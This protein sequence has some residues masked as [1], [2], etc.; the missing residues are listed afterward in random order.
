MDDRAAAELEIVDPLVEGLGDGKIDISTAAQVW[1]VHN[2][3]SAIQSSMAAQMFTR[4][5]PGWQ[6]IVHAL[7]DFGIQERNIKSQPYQ[8]KIPE[9]RNHL[10]KV[11]VDWIPMSDG[12]ANMN[13]YFNSPTPLWY[14]FD[15]KGNNCGLG[16]DSPAN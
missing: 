6:A 5:R 14:V 12:G 3:P 1:V 7:T 13:L 16:G 4:R 2:I 10:G 8:A 11:I 9:G 15:A